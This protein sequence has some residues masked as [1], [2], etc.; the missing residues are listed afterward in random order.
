MDLGTAT[1]A[2]GTVALIIA[3]VEILKGLPVV[4]HFTPATALVLGL[5]FS[6]GAFYAGAPNAPPDLYTAILTGLGLGVAAVGS[7]TAWIKTQP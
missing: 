3:L 4:D 5:A 2:G 6:L 1:V 7:H